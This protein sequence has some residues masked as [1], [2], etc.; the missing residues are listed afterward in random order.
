[1]VEGSSY[2]VTT[3]LFCSSRLAAV[4][5]FLI[6]AAPQLIFLLSG[7]PRDPGVRVLA[8]NGYSTALCG[9]H[10]TSLFISSS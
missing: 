5:V 8:R 1:M 7:V 2:I 3:L 6:S 4:S 10:E 9:A